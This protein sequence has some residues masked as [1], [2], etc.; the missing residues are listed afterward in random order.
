MITT[1]LSATEASHTFSEVLNRVYYQ[2]QTFEIKRGKEIVARIV[3]V[4]TPENKKIS[5]VMELNDFF[6]RLPSLDVE[7]ATKFSEDI[8]DIRTSDKGKIE[9]WD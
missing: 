3:P 2:G 6:N 4:T 1:I 8:K 9:P 5:S 7:D